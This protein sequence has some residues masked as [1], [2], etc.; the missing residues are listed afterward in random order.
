[1][2]HRFDSGLSHHFLNPLSLSNS[3]CLCLPPALSSNPRPIAA[4]GYLF[5]P[6]PK[7]CYVCDAPATCR[8]HVPARGIFPTESEFRKSLI[9]VPSCAAHN[10]DKSDEDEFLRWILISAPR[11]RIVRLIVSALAPGWTRVGSD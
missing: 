8:E 7:T 6:V 9:T 11:K 5:M 10:T 4:V 1:M 3:G 2:C